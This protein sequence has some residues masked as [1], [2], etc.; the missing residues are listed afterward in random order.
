MKNNE[1]KQE[2]YTRAPW[3]IIPGDYRSDGRI[4]RGFSILTL[5]P[6]IQIC[7]VVSGNNTDRIES[8]AE[9]NAERIVK[10][11]NAMEGIDD[12]QKFVDAHKGAIDLMKETGNDFIKLARLL[13]KVKE[14]KRILLE[15]FNGMKRLHL[16]QYKEGTI[17]NQCYK[18]MNEAIEIATRKTSKKELEDGK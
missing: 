14:D 4:V 9:A 16:E 8:V 6:T 10:C 17:G 12:P 13:L 18:Q 15:A 2:S 11:V 1:N 5:S 7:S 3:R